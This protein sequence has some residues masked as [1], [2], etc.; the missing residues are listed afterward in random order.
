VAA[1]LAIR[2]LA[3]LLYAQ[4]KPTVRARPIDTT[5]CEIAGDS[6][7]FD[8]K[9]VRFSARF[10]NDGIEHCALVDSKCNRGI[11]PFVPDEV[12]HH[13][14]IEAF[15]RALDQGNARNKG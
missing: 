8:G 11:I 6:Q 4:T 9:K 2:C 14:D 15:V 7:R 10:E 5:L 12:E 13:F 3:R 1:I